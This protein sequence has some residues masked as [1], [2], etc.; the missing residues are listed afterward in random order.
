M[1]YEHD[2]FAAEQEFKRAIELNPGYALARHWYGEVYLSA[3]GRLDESIAQ[4]KIAHEIDPLSPGIITGLAWSY[5]GKHQYEEAVALCQQALALDSQD[6]SIYSYR[7]MAL[8]KLNRFEEAIHDAQKAYEMEPTGSNR[9]MLGAMYASAG[10][11]EAASE[12]IEELKRT[13]QPNDISKYDLAI[14]LAA[15]NELD[16]AFKL[17]N[18][19][20]SPSTVD[21]LSIRIDPMLDALRSDER[22]IT[23]ERK[24]NL[25]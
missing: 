19:E 13:P 8:M 15:Q 23:L 6:W 14:I 12:I 4:L 10:K 18:E 21:L 1:D 24:L 2:W 9:A 7:A 5:I 3:M 25:P 16:E 17:L 22:F 11:R 20:A